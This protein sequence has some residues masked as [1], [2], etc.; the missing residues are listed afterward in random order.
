MVAGVLL[1]GV[2][3]VVQT[4][5]GL[6]AGP[7]RDPD[8]R[9]GGL[10]LVLASGGTRT[11]PT[12][13]GPRTCLRVSLCAP[14]RPLL[15]PPALHRPGVLFS[16]GGGAGSSRREMMLGRAVLT[17]WMGLL[18]WGAA[19]PWGSRAGSGERRCIRPSSRRCWGARSG[20]GTE[21]LAG[22][23]CSQQGTLSNR[24]VVGVGGP[25]NGHLPVVQVALVHQGHRKPSPGSSCSRWSS[26]TAPLRAGTRGQC[27]GGTRSRVPWA[28]ALLWL[29]CRSPPSAPWIYGAFNAKLQGLLKAGKWIPGP[30][31]HAHPGGRV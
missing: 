8:R 27:W 14:S 30:E 1:A 16:L 2:V 31:S 26:A 6:G 10:H 20:S 15:G 7:Q 29:C 9:R 22:S 13:T 12:P 28:Q 5:R 3:L 23:K 4:R 25:Q 17:F 24:P 21:S 19:P 11:L 18:C